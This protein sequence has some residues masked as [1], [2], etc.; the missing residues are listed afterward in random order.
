[1]STMWPSSKPSTTRP[2]KGK[3]V[4]STVPTD[5]V[6][7]IVILLLILGM[8]GGLAL[9][10]WPMVASWYESMQTITRTLSVGGA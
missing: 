3:P 5:W 8:I 1:M 4:T 7:G 9:F 6:S 10:V 2:S